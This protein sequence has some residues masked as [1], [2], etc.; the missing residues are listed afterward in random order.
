MYDY[1]AA[2]KPILAYGSLEGDATEILHTSKS[3]KMFTYE[4][5]NESSDFIYEAIEKWKENKKFIEP[6]E[7]Y[8][9]SFSRRNLT[10]KLADI[11]NQHI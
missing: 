8:I 6:N 1:M 2:G 4:Q 7:E 3:G 11:F 9:E 10:K 5:I